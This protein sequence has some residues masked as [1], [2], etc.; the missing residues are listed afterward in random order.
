MNHGLPRTEHAYICSGIHTTRCQNKVQ[1]YQINKNDCYRSE[2]YRYKV[3]QGA[4]LRNA[5]QE[6]TVVFLHIGYYTL[7]SSEMTLLKNIV[8]SVREILLL[9]SVDGKSS[10]GGL[11]SKRILLTSLIS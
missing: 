7:V 3:G 8:A 5:T 1:V 4:P 6:S 11:T 10:K 9:V 2:G